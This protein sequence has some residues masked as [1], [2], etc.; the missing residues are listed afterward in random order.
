MNNPIIDLENKLCQYFGRK[1]CIL[2]GR[3]T[4]AIYI[5]LKALGIRNGKVALPTIVNPSP[6]NAVLYAGLEP[7]FCD[8]NL[9]DFTIDIAS[10]KKLI[11]TESEL[12]AIIAVHIFGQPADMD[13]ILQI[14]KSK[15]LYVIEDDAQA[16]GARYH[17]KKVG[18]LG[19]VSVV[20]F[21]HTKIIDVGLGGAV[22]TDDDIIASRLRKE[23]QCLPE[24]PTDLQE[25][26]EDYRTAYYALKVLTETS[27]RLNDLFLTM[28]Y[29]F[30]DMYLFKIDEDIAIRVIKEIDNL[31]EY[32]LKRKNN[33]L[34][35]QQGLKHPAI[36]HPN[37]K[38][39][40]VFWRYSF[41]VDGNIQK[42][43]SERMRDEGFDI[44]NWYPPIHHWYQSGKKQQKD[45]FKN[46]EYFASHVCN[47]WTE[48]SQS[49]ERIQNTIEVLL[50]IIDE[51]TSDG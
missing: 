24:I 45:L 11:E 16:M 44:S 21:A 6:A 38:E 40:G 41:I 43:I 46:A 26:S 7:V 9:D 5:G 39:D 15:G 18:S 27:P 37:Y 3:C 25:M 19:D 1:H 35:Y 20:S 13:Q 23:V 17:G 49:K 12:K 47:L 2:T 4:A 14:A 28:P 50:R 8:I 22:L 36:I 51:E 10:L 48:P 30:K 34:E 29:I 31:D 33:A 32:I 42:K